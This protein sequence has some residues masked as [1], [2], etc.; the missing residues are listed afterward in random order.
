MTKNKSIQS[1]NHRTYMCDIVNFSPVPSIEFDVMQN[2]LIFNK[3]VLGHF[4]CL[5]NGGWN[6]PLLTGLDALL[7]KTLQKNEMLVFYREINM[8]NFV[9]EQKIYYY[10]DKKK[11]YI[12]I[13]DTNHTNINKNIKLEVNNKL[14][15]LKEE[16]KELESKLH[17]VRNCYQ[18][19]YSSKKHL[20]FSLE[21]SH[22]GTWT[23]DIYRDRFVLDD[24]ALLLLGISNN[25]LSL[26]LDSIMHKIHPEDKKSFHDKL[27][28]SWN[29]NELFHAELRIVHSDDSVHRLM[30]KGKLYDNKL[31]GNGVLTGAFFRPN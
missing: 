18:Q 28:F 10:P 29:S 11:L 23:W 1:S 31:G 20:E 6:H 13:N 5:F 19:L 4:P 26:N 12:Y 24:T 7:K 15:L 22:V 2:M 27:T 25:N 8:I 21:A 17:H 16:N 14:E 9:Y 30:A 3:A